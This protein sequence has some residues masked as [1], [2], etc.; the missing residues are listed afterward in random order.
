MKKAILVLEVLCLAVAA[1][2]GFRV[3][4]IK[5]KKPEQFQSRVTI[6]GVTFAA[7]LLLDGK[8]QK[9]YFYKEL[10]PSNLIAVRLAVFNNGKDEVVL[11]LDG[12]Q[13]LGPD[14]NKI[15]LVGPETVAQA[16]LQGMLVAAKAKQSAPI[17]VTP[18]GVDDP[19]SDPS[20]PRYDPRMDPNSPN[21]DPNDPRNRGQYPS[22]SYPPGSAPG[23]YPP[24]GTTPGSYPSG[25]YPSGGTWGRPSVILNPGGG[26]SGDLSQFERQLVEKDFSDKAHT[27]EPVLSSVSRDRFLYFSIP[28]QPAATKGYALHLSVS[29]GIPQEVVLKF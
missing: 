5:P 26:D 14:G 7:D 9:S 18:G 28:S 8:D 25:S 19:R 10:T 13:L 20:D 29:K 23:S 24:P 17:R 16:V 27:S 6:A 21:Y 11:P 3:K 2:A 4:N 1:L 15:P 22:T 12:L